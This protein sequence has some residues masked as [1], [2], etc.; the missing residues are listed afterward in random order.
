MFRPHPLQLHT[1]AVAR[2]GAR[3]EGQARPVVKTKYA[4][5]GNGFQQQFRQLVLATLRV[6]HSWGFPIVRSNSATALYSA[7][8]ISWHHCNPTPNNTG[9]LNSAGIL[10]WAG[11]Y[12]QSAAKPKP[13]QNKT[14]SKPSL[15]LEGGLRY[16][17]DAMLLALLLTRKAHNNRRE[18][19]QHARRQL[20][21]PLF[22]SPRPATTFQPPTPPPLPPPAEPPPPPP[23]CATIEGGNCWP[24]SFD[25]QGSSTASSYSQKSHFYFT[26]LPR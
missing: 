21:S 4:F 19:R 6:Q 1:H 12:Q 2:E 14:K 5:T 11:K 15:R 22:S 8:E 7:G 20:E 18:S 16:T 24:S 26:T 17:L 3:R 10:Y 23:R 25:W 13:R 9:A